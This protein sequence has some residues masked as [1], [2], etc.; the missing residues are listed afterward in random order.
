MPVTL[1]SKTTKAMLR[2]VNA[3]YLSLF[4]CLLIGLEFYINKD[5]V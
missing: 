5:A 1:S 2:G 4:I 3:I